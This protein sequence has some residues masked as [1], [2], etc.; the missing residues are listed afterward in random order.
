MFEIFPISILSSLWE[1]LLMEGIQDAVKALEHN[2]LRHGGRKRR[3]L[4]TDQSPYLLHQQ[5]LYVLLP[6]NAGQLNP[7]HPS[8]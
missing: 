4:L 1:N 7:P 8:L 6:V 5:P 2:H 3:V